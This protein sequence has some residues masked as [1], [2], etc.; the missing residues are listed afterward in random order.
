VLKPPEVILEL[1]DSHATDARN[2]RE[3][4]PVLTF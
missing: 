1:A 4:D 3:G 2:P